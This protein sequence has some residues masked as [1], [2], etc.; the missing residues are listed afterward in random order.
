MVSSKVQ[1]L[2]KLNQ[3]FYMSQ[4]GEVLKYK[5]ILCFS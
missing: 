3:F 4:K 1:K 5:K 2:Q